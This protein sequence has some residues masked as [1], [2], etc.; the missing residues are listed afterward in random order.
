MGLLKEHAAVDDTLEN[1]IRAL[2]PWFH[3][4]RIHGIE[5]APDHFLGD[6]PQIKFAAFRD[7][8][9]EDMSGKSVLDIGCNAGFYS[10]EMKRRGA[11]RV[12]GI[13]TDEHYLRQARFAAEMEEGYRVMADF[14][15][16]L[17]EADMAAGFE[18]LTES[19]GSLC[20]STPRRKPILRGTLCVLKVVLDIGSAGS[21]ALK[22]ARSGRRLVALPGIEPGFED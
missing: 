9:P 20:Q 10:L 15:L 3:N 21:D 11:E 1:R 5:T 18:V 6:Y 13:D 4:L 14:D 19:S 16:A 8:I 17:A 12:L 22:R 2:G 7:A